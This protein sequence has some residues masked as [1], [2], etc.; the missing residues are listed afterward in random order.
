MESSRYFTIFNIFE[1][2]NEFLNKVKSQSDIDEIVELHQRFLQLLVKNCL[3]KNKY[4][5]SSIHEVFGVILE[6]CDTW[7]KGLQCRLSLI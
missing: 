1:M 6:F 7:R 5:Q 3:L 2:S 4:F